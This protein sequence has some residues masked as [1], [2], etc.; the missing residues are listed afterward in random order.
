M[1][2]ICF[3]RPSIA[4]RIVRHSVLFPHP[5][6]QCI[7]PP[8]SPL[9]TS[10]PPRKEKAPCSTPTTGT[11]AC[12]LLPRRYPCGFPR[13]RQNTGETDRK[14]EGGC[15]MTHE[16]PSHAPRNK[17]YRAGREREIEASRGERQEIPNINLD[18]LIPSHPHLIH[19]FS[20]SQPE[21][22]NIFHAQR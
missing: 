9:P 7:S 6:F 10:P 13:T 11:E 15:G 17:G 20:I 3:A 18:P 8:F 19:L 14:R 21:K 1:A 5:V 4:P 2:S 22:F 16:N 12:S